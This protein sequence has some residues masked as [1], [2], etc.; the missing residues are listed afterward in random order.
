MQAAVWRIAKESNNYS[1]AK[2]SSGILSQPVSDA[3]DRNSSPAVKGVVHRP[4]NSS[5]FRKDDPIL[6]YRVTWIC[7]ELFHERF[8]GPQHTLD[9]SMNAKSIMSASWP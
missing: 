2:P 7:R 4:G 3:D 6:A 5:T 9:L 1:L 8:Y